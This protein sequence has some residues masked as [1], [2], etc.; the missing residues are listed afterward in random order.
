VA[1]NTWINMTIS[2]EI[3]LAVCVYNGEKYMADTLACI[4]AQTLRTFD[5]LIVD[6]CSTDGTVRVIAD[7][8]KKSP[9]DYRLIRLEKNGGIAH[10]RQVALEQAKTPYLLF[11]DADDLPHKTLVE[12]EYRLISSDKNIMGVSSWLEYIDVSGEKLPGGQFMGDKTKEEFMLRASRGKLI[13]LPIQTMFDRQ[14]ALDAG[15]FRLDGF[16]EGKPRYRD[17]CED[18]DLWTRMSDLYAQG[19]YM[20]S[21]PEVLYS[22]RKG[23]TGLSSNTSVMILKIKY[24]KANLRL[25]RAGKSEFT[26]V[27]FYDSLSEKELKEIKKEAIAADEL[28]NGV[29]YLKRGKIGKGVAHIVR[30]AYSRPGYIWQKIKKNSG[31]FK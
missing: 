2:R 25:R 1:S 27:D 16:P 3:T 29:F 20:V 10:A 12:K 4:A 15:G 5:L 11:V 13:F 21:I 24:V 26:F 17:F 8:F 14:A 9:G 30:S 6:D 22:Y 19:R 7:Y 28:R 18:L 31:L 23:N